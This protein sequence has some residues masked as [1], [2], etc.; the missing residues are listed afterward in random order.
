VIPPPPRFFVKFIVKGV[1]GLRP[2]GNII[3]TQSLASQRVTPSYISQDNMD[4]DNTKLN[5]T[6]NG[7][8]EDYKLGK[9]LATSAIVSD[10][11]LGPLKPKRTKLKLIIL[12]VI[13]G[14]V[15]FAAYSNR[16]DASQA[17]TVLSGYTDLISE[18]KQF[19]N[20]TVTGESLWPLA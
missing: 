18:K 16:A 9:I 17:T 5:F 10:A 2:N 7:V 11:P 6:K 14:Y 15:G 20:L 1:S 13:L 12:V 19:F 4:N 3:L 8:K